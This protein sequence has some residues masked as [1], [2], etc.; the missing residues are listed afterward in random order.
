MVICLEGPSAVGKTT[1]GRALAEHCGAAVILE[2]NALFQRPVD[3]TPTWYFERQ[4][5]RWALAQE[6]SRKGRIAI[7]DGDPFQ[8]FWYN[9]A[10]DFQ[11]WQPLKELMNFYRPQ[12]ETARLMFPDRYFLLTADEATL[13][14]QRASDMTRSRRGFETH[15]RFIDPQKRYFEAMETISPGRVRLMLA[16]SVDNMVESIMNS[17]SERSLPSTDQAETDTSLALFDALIDWLE[18]NHAS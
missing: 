14:S 1:L 6:E 9:W 2:V 8:P 5:D 10:Y 15:L 16:T 11:G 12:I 17:F 4:L 13:R 7:L 18:R 3:E